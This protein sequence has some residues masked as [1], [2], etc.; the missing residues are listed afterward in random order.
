MLLY[1]AI[2]AGE[3]RDRAS[4][5]CWRRAAFVWLIA[6]EVWRNQTIKHACRRVE[7]RQLTSLLAAPADLPELAEGGCKDPGLADHGGDLE[8]VEDLVAGCAFL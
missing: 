5:A 3:R 1:V 8:G 6:G 2:S 7:H 4:F